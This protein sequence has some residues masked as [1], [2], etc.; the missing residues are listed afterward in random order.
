MNEALS[1]NLVIARNALGDL[2]GVFED[3]KS[4]EHQLASVLLHNITWTLSLDPTNKSTINTR[5]E[6]LYNNSREFYDL[7]T[8][9]HRSRGWDIVSALWRAKYYDAPTCTMRYPSSRDT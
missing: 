5:L 3:K 9:H 7:L 8:Y 1:I 6:N 2:L 4:K